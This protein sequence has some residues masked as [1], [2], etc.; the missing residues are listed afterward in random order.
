[1]RHERDELEEV[2]AGVEQ[3]LSEREDQLS[4]IYLELDNA[5]SSDQVHREHADRL[6]SELE[7]SRIII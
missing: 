3:K 7:L 5:L 1:M 2:V 6:A 4:S